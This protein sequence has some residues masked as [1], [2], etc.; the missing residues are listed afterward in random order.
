MNSEEL[1]WL[2]RRHGIEMTHLSGGSH[3]GAVLSVADIIA[4][5]YTEVMHF[6]S[7]NPEWDERDRFILSKRTCW[8]GDLCGVGGERIFPGGR[9]ENTLSEWKSSVW[10]CIP[11]FA[12][13]GFFYR[14]F[15]TWVIC[16]SWDGVCC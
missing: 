4:V 3:I 11:P 6:D 5:L 8:S 12:G 9:I 15:G 14:F 1:S 7:K 13:S 16:S 2:I 10:T